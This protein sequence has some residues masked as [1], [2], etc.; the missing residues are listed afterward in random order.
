MFGIDKNTSVY[1]FGQRITTDTIYG[2]SDKGKGKVNTSN[3]KARAS[4]DKKGNSQSDNPDADKICI[5]CNNKGH[6]KQTVG[7][8]S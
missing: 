7:E 2:M 3:I 5:H 4:Q 1:Q 6:R 8:G